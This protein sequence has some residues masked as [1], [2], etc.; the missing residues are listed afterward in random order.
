MPQHAQHLQRLVDDAVAKGAKLLNGGKPPAVGNPLSAGQ[1]YPPT[2][3]ADVTEDMFIMQEEIFGPIMCI[4]RLPDGMAGDEEAVRCHS[5]AQCSSTIGI[6]LID[7]SSC[8][9]NTSFRHPNR[10]GSPTTAISPYHP[11]VTLAAPNALPTS[12]IDS[13]L[14][15]LRS[16]TSKAPPICRSHCHLG[17][18]DC[19]GH[20]CKLLRIAGF[21]VSA[22]ADCVFSK[23]FCFSR[24]RCHLDAPVCINGTPPPGCKSSGFDRFAGVEGLRGLCHVKSIVTDR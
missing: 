6:L 21:G 18:R 22:F 5:H 3:L 23:S 7:P 19:L 11:A 16:T 2:V 20:C 15:W 12:A 14:E 24:S 10:F 8:M 4:T 1:F 9:A 17:V 13:R